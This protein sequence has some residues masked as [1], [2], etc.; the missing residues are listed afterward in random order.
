MGRDFYS[1]IEDIPRADR[2][3]GA[4]GR[5]KK[6]RKIGEHPRKIIGW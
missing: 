2:V 3:M 1:G 4:P 5:R 6:K